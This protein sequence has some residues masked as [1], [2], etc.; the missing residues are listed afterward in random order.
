MTEIA[1]GQV[2]AC[3]KKIGIATVIIST[4]PAFEFSKKRRLDTSSVPN[5]LQLNIGNDDLSITNTSD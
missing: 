3:G 4:A 5:S 2:A 1:P